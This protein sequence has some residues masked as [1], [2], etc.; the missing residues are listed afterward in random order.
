MVGDPDGIFVGLADVGFLDGASDGANVMGELDGISDGEVDG[1]SDGDCVGVDDVG[2][3][4]GDLEGCIEGDI[5]GVDVGCGCIGAFVGVVVGSGVG[6]HDLRIIFENVPLPRLKSDGLFVLFNRLLIH[7]TG[8]DAPR[9]SVEVVPPD[10]TGVLGHVC[11][12]C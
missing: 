3:V 7:H 8:I 9:N 11:V 4:E 5:D 6:H 10:S 2:F 1:K 12:Y